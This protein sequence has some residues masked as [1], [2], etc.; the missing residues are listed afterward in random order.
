MSDSSSFTSRATHLN[1]IEL[2][3]HS[4]GGID[5]YEWF[6]KTISSSVMAGL[7]TLVS[8]LK[9]V[10]RSCFEAIDGLSLASSICLA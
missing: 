4:L 2:R 9:C 1:A 6:V 10:I 7:V 5:H 8:I 3:T